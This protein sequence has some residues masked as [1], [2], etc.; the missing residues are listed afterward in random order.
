[1]NATYIGLLS[2]LVHCC[3][4]GQGGLFFG[5]VFLN[6]VPLV[7]ISSTPGE[8]NPTNGPPGAYVGSDYTA[9]LYYLEGS[10]TDQ[11][12][13]EAN[14]PAL[15]QPADTHFLGITGHPPSTGTGQF[16]KGSIYL[17]TTG[18]VT[19][20]V[21]AWYHG[22][23]LFE[24]YDE[25]L[26]KGQNVGR[27]NPVLVLLAVGVDPP[28]MLDG[29]QPFTVSVPEPSVLSLIGLGGLSLIRLR[30]IRRP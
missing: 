4:H 22:D 26:A 16:Q 14:N 17:P 8:F 9:S 2:C 10:V 7:S 20:Q 18:T 27:S 24:S 3:T 15:F 6:P 28:P 25:A 5:N 21:R 11:S 30:T 19:V 29:L 23:G 12:E 1:M 13:F